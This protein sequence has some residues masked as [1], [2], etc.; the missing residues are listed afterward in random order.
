MDRLMFGSQDVLAFYKA[1]TVPH[2]DDTSVYFYSL[3]LK[4]HFQVSIL[5]RLRGPYGLQTL[6]DLCQKFCLLFTPSPKGLLPG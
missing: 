5:S 3:E 1:F 6:E 2:S 4:H